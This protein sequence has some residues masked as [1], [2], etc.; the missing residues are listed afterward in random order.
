MLGHV[1]RVTHFFGV[2]ISECK[3]TTATF[4]QVEQAFVEH[5]SNFGLTFGTQAEYKFRLNLFA[6]KDKEYN[7]INADVKNTFTV[8]HNKFSTWTDTEYGKLLGEKPSENCGPS[9]IFEQVSYPNGGIDWR[10]KGVVNAVKNQG[11]CGSCWT[12]SGTSAIESHHAIKTGELLSLAE[13]QIVDC[14]HD[15]DVAGCEGGWKTTAMKYTMQHGQELESDYPYTAKDGSCAYDASKGRV[16]AKTVNCVAPRN[17]AQLLTALSNKG[18]MAVSVEA[19]ADVFRGYTSGVLNSDECG[20][21][22]NH[23]IIAVGWGVEAGQTYYI[24]RNS[25]GADWGD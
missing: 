9:Y 3:N 12:F 6:L 19:D 18:P 17:S 7:R 1:C 2:D 20:T 5:I 16:H 10:T 4:P 14:A 15:D 11:H 13:Q 21:S 22:T 24:V 25:W 23:A 8:G